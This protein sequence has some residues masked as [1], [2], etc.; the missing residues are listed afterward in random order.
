MI[1]GRITFLRPAAMAT[2]RTAQS[3]TRFSD[4]NVYVTSRSMWEISNSA[5][6]CGPDQANPDRG[7]Q[8]R[9]QGAAWFRPIYECWIAVPTCPFTF[10]LFDL[11]PVAMITGGI[12]FLRPGA[13]ATGRT[14][15]SCTR[16]SDQNVYVT[17]RS[18]WEQQRLEDR[19]RREPW[20]TPVH[21]NSGRCTWLKSFA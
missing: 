4:Q 3:C 20:R 14:A 5:R 18:M 6:G 13:M 11:R 17:S 15:Q 7:A 16:F 10:D 21:R 19:I 2:R 1:T 12:A 8:R 9:G